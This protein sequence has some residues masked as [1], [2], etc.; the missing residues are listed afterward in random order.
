M[1]TAETD[2]GII[3]LGHPRS[4]TTLLRR[5]LNVHPAIAAPP[6]THIF[7]SIAKIL[8]V[9]MTAE[10]VDMGLLSGLSFIG[11]EDDDVLAQLRALSFGFLNNFA[12]AQGKRRWAEKTAF[13]IFHLDA[14]EKICAEHV[15]YV[16][17][18]RH[19]FDVARSCTEFCADA[20]VYPNSLH[21]YIRAYPQ[22]VEA[23]V[24]SWIDTT[25]ALID[26]GQRKP[27]R[28]VVVRYEDLVDNPEAT[29]ADIVTFVGEQSAGLP[30]QEA[31]KAEAI[32][33]F[34]DHKGYGTTRVHG[35][36]VGHWKS[37]PSPQVARL[38]RLVNP[39]LN[40]CGYDLINETKPLSNGDAR[41]RYTKSLAIHAARQEHKP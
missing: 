5:L 6:E 30:W 8:D 10:G 37:I 4:G 15:Y 32:H 12:L 28:C 25:Y 17:I 1:T 35:T 2:S 13:S 31:L 14:I 26:L 18:I 11:F 38:G 33:G 21:T 39:L 16:G 23:F 9:D 7:N 29:L 3:I 19:P 22:P 27:D 20:G 40:Q 24:R 34:S 41:K 36:S